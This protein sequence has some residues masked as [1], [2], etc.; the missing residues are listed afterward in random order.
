MKTSTHKERVNS[1]SLGHQE[2]TEK[3]SNRK[4]CVVTIT[5]CSISSSQCVVE[6]NDMSFYSIINFN[7]D[8]DL[9]L[10]LP[11]NAYWQA[12]DLIS[13][14]HSGFTYEVNKSRQLV[15]SDGKKMT[16]LTGW[17]LLRNSFCNDKLKIEFESGKAKQIL[18]AD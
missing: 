6:K 16:A 11:I 7:S 14:N 18:V 4:D 1:E 13:E 17:V 15:R 10:E 9:P 2:L 3:E 5:D 8:V 12:P